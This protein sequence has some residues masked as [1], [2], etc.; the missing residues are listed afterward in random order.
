M[1]IPKAKQLPSDSWSC[2]VRVNDQDIEFP[3]N[4][5]GGRGG[6]YSCQGGDDL[7]KKVCQSQN[8]ICRD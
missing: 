6:S 3:P 1:K 5:K 2:R 8:G 4:R 7:G